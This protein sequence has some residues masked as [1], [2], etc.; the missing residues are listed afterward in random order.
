MH[1][2]NDGKG[3]GG[4]AGSLMKSHGS[5]RSPYIEIQKVYREAVQP[6]PARIGE[7]TM[8]FPRTTTALSKDAPEVADLGRGVAAAATTAGTVV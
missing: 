2:R 1:F 3:F 5:S 7:F 4:A 6:E 8:P